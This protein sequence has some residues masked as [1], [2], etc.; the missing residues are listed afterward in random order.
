MIRLGLGIRIRRS[1]TT[2]FIIPWILRTG[3][4]DDAAPWDDTQVWKDS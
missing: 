1:H 4:W 3:F 2:G